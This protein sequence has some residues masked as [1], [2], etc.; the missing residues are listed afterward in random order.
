MPTGSGLT[1][2]QKYEG[3]LAEI[4]TLLDDIQKIRTLTT[5]EIAILAVV[6]RTLPED[7]WRR[8]IKFGAI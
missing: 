4:V 6:K 3:V 2:E 1:L 5:T 8:R 7:E